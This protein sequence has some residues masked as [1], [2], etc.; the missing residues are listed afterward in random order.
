VNVDPDDPLC[1]P[2]S[3]EDAMALTGRSRRTIE[4]WIHEGRLELVQ[5]SPL[6]KVLVERQVVDAEQRARQAVRRGRPRLS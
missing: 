4:R 3:V 1:R 2:I 6:E 5:I